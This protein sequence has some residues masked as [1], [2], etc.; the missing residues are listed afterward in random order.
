M[1]QRGPNVCLK[2][3]EGNSS[4]LPPRV[5]TFS[6]I[7]LIVV[8]VFVCCFIDIYMIKKIYFFGTSL[9]PHFVYFVYC[10][11]FIHHYIVKRSLFFYTLINPRH[12]ADNS[13][14]SDILISLFILYL[15]QILSSIAN[16]NCKA[17][18]PPPPSKVICKSRLSPA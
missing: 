16:L 1:I 12:S 10:D 8:F 18:K 5:L 14:T 3:A 4:A 13:Y 2:I 17:D 15:R 7:Q 6:S 9:I 11:C